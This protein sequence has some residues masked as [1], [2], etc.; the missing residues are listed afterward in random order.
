V[1]SENFRVK[2]QNSP[3]ISL[4]HV[5]NQLEIR[6][7]YDADIVSAVKSIP[8]RK[9]HPKER[10]WSIP[11]TPEAES[12][13]KNKLS[14][15]GR[16]K[17]VSH[18]SDI[19]IQEDLIKRYLEHL[20][21]K[22]YSRHT[23]KNYIRH[24]ELFLSYIGNSKIDGKAIIAYLDYLVSDKEVS[25]AYQQMAVNAIRYLVV[26]ILGD[27]MPKSSL[28]PK[29]EQSLPL[30]LSIR[31][32][33]KILSIT[34]NIKHKLVIL[35][36]YSAGLR[37]SEAVNLQ[38]NDIDYD[39]KIITV[40]RGKGKKDRQVPLSTTLEEFLSK[41]FKEYKPSLYLFEGQK[42]GKYSVRSVQSIFRKACMKAGIKKPVTVHSLRHS[43]ATHLLES[44]TDLRIIQEL[45]GHKSSK[46]TEIYTH[47]S[48]RTIAGV[49]SPADD[50][51]ISG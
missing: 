4:T 1:A 34:S 27:K 50:L 2:R 18:K 41:Y 38:L 3:I 49:R 29:R 32:V 8:N 21:R 16:V 5:D 43:Y 24:I 9:Y 48:S 17:M 35:L 42:G 37:V 14:R 33:E 28:R 46:T 26:H 47:V 10:Y 23:I 51:D 15:Y 39:R 20:K 6:F 30:V 31:E 40:R 22:R 7:P 12:I 11:F 19:S 13:V 45:L 25:S 44:G 36:T